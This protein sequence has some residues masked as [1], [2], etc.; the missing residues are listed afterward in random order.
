MDSIR[1][2]LGGLRSRGFFWVLRDRGKGR[3]AEDRTLHRSP[4]RVPGRTLGRRQL[5]RCGNGVFPLPPAHVRHHRFL[6]PLFFAQDV[7]NEPVLAVRVRRSGQLCRP[8]GTAVVGIPSPPSPPFRRHRRR[9]PLALPARFLVEP[10]RMAHHP[11]AL[12]DAQSLRPGLG[13]LSGVGLDQPFRHPGSL[14]TGSG[15]LPLRQRVGGFCPLNRAPTA[16]RCSSGGSL[17]RPRS[18][19]TPR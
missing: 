3:L 13:P 9:S 15:A 17:S 5:A 16:L 6:S 10:H 2:P 8:T 11:Q 14:F 7:P 4:R 18:S 1:H 19:F 12:S